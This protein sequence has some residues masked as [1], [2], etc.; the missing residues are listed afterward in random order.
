MIGVVLIALSFLCAMALMDFQVFHASAETW[1][2]WNYKYWMALGCVAVVFSFGLAFF[3]DSLGVPG[4]Q[5][6]AIFATVMLLFIGGFLDIF[7]AIFAYY[8]GE[9]YTFDVWS[10][11]Y[12]WFV[13]TGLLE[14]WTWT[15]QIIWIGACIALIVV[16]WWKALEK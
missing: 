6:I 14:E 15:H 13:V 7:F 3:A 1:P 11:Q 5:S 16:I 4:K 2:E 8:R 9:G 12:K 10:A